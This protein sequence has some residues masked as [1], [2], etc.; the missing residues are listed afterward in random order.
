MSII[1]PYLFTLK[2][3]STIFS[4]DSDKPLWPMK[5]S[6][7]DTKWIEN[8]HFVHNDKQSKNDNMIISYT[9]S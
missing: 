2:V 3:D 5:I 8:I 6:W 1:Y 9:H 4:G 7:T